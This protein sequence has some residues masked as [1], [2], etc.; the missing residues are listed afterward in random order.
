MEKGFIFIWT[1]KELTP[2]VLKMGRKWGFRYVENIAWIKLKNNNTIAREK[3]K[4]VCKS[5]N[6]CLILRKELVS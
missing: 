2:S 6:T 4:Y 5:K 1:E 3:S